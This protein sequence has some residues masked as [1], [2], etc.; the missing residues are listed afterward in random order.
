MQRASFFHDKNAGKGAEGML[1]KFSVKRPYTVIVGVI[2]VIVLGIVSFTKMTTDLLP[3]MNLPYALVI[4]TDVGAS[5]EE[6]ESDVTAPIES[7][8]ATT[9]DIKNV[10][11]MSYDSYSMVVIEYEQSANMDSIL[12]EIQ[13]ELDQLEGSFP[14]GVGTPVIMQIDPDMMPIMVASAD[15]EG[16]SQKEISE[17]VE[18]ELA[19]A[20]TSVSG[21]ASV[22]TTGVLE[23]KVQVTLDNDKIKALNE[24]IQDKIEEQFTGAQEEL[25]QAAEEIADGKAQLENGKEELASQMGQAEN[26]MTN[27]KIEAFVSES[28]L[29]QNSMTLAAAK[30]LIE[31]AIPELQQIYQDGKQ[32]QL[33]I[34][35]AQRLNEESTSA[36]EQQIEDLENQITGGTTGSSETGDTSQSAALDALLNQSGVDSNQLELLK[37][38]LLETNASLS[39]Q[40]GTQLAAFGVNLSAVDDIPQAIATLSEKLIEIN[41]AM[42]TIDAAKVQVEAG[43]TTLDDAYVTLNKTEIA[44]ILEMSDASAKLADGENQLTLGQAQLDESKETAK[45]SADLNTILTVENLAGILTAQNFSMPAGYVQQKDASYLV[46]V[47]DKVDSPES[48]EQMVLIDLGMD[49]MEPVRLGD[50]AEVEVVDNAADSYSKLNGNPAIMLSIEKQTGYSTGDVA[51]KVKEKFASLEK[52][53]D[54]LRMTILMNQGVYIDLIVKSVLENMIVGAFLAIMVLILFLKDIK[55]TLVIA[56]SI[57]LSV[58][59]AIVLMYFTGIS[60]NIISLSG[61]ALGIGMLVDNSIVVIENIYR[62][63]HEGYSIRKAAVEGAGQVAGAIFASTLTTICVFTPI[64]FTEGITRQLFVDIALTIAYTLTASLIVALTFVPMMAAG[65]LKHPKEVKQGFFEKVQQEYRK[66]IVFALKYKV[67]VLIGVVVLLAASMVLAL[68]RGFSFMDMGMEADQMTVTVAPKDGEN[69][70]FTE[71]SERADEVVEKVSGIEGIDAIG[72]MAGG[73]NVMSMGS[74]SDTATLYLLLEEGSSVTTDAITDQIVALTKDMDCEVSVDASSSDMT[75]FFGS[76]ISVQISGSNLD[77]LQELAEEVGKIVEQTEGTVDVDDG[78]DNTTPS[79]TIHVD[80]EKAAKYSMTT[81]QV[82]QLVYAKMASATSA[83]TISGDLKDY[84]V[85]VRTKEQT[86]TTLEDIKKLTFSYTD[87]M[88]ETTEVKLKDIATFEEGTSLNIIRRDA[89][90]RY[91]SVTAGI[92]ET[93]NVTLVSRE[94][95]KKLDQIELPEGYSIT[96]TGEDETIREAM[97]QL[98]LMLLLAV[99]FIYLIMVAQFQSFLSPFI[100]MFTIPLAFTGGFLALFFTGKEVSVIAM[101]GFVM[102]AGIIVNNGIVMVDYIN[103]LRR[104]GVEKREAIVESGVTRLRPILMTAL[105]TI[106]SMSTMALGLGDGSEMM[107]PMAIVTEG[108]LIYGTLLTLIVVP[109]IYDLFT[110]NKSM[111]E[112]EL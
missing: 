43:K 20:V 90:N 61:L 96:M 51:K 48:L 89:Q 92:D 30:T 76:G 16:M 17:Y 49:D 109:C 57:P 37:Y 3:D 86:G 59:F 104:G 36:L 79:F 34:E 4:T 75:S 85:Y 35:Q 100:I 42:A 67:V 110:S 91:I 39:A 45:A 22:S 18:E 83:T 31:A 82:F 55:P 32:L 28:D 46:R 13:Q 14:D 40:W 11:S 23:E 81:A 66:V 6:V 112:E 44:S 64:V 98:Y 47:G 24:T 19:P 97:D 26:E 5:P 108:G 80:K 15:I 2:L 93:H 68:S 74:D 95:Q 60:L 88:G 8:M 70:T 53:K 69:L 12:I 77:Q 111:V 99:I 101:I 9:S 63:Q 27:G 73:A 58:I 54:G 52:Q 56:C 29:N 10:S 105:T 41:T 78:L 103:Q 72:A 7:A 84:A 50:V 102:L 33:Q 94:M 1:S 71:L 38:Q 106:L 62:L 25:D 21:V 65:I 87:K 107:Q